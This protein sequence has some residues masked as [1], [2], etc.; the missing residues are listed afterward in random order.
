MPTLFSRTAQAELETTP[1]PW[2]ETWTPEGV[3][4]AQRYLGL[5]GAITL[6]YTADAGVNGEYYA[7]ACLGCTYRTARDGKS[8]YRDLLSEQL[9]GHFA[10]EHSGSCRAL[11]RPL[12]ERP[13]DESARDI[14]RR[15]L[16]SKRS[17]TDDSLVFLTDFHLE[18]LALQRTTTWIETELHRLAD[19][20]PDVL[21][22]QPRSYGPGY[23]FTLH[24]FPRA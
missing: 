13:D 17:G 1:E 16:H 14:V 24:A 23:E 20:H 7:V 11:P 9:A 21:T 22:A 19:D 8:T 15:C 2:P 18:R 12:P 10:N 6:V 3:I 5:A 4:V